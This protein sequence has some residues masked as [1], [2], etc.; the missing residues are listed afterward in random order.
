M[1]HE[2]RFLLPRRALGKE[3]IVIEVDQEG[4]RLG[5]LK[6]SKGAV[7]W[8]PGHKK[9]GFKMRWARFDQAMRA[10]TRGDFD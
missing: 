5:T 1:A 6:I 8:Y 7:V 2:V 3:N 9:L 10:G 4:E